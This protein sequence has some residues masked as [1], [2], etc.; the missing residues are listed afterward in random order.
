[1]KCVPTAVIPSAGIVPG[2]VCAP[3]MTYTAMAEEPITVNV[4][5]RFGSFRNSA[6]KTPLQGRIRA[7]RDQ[8]QGK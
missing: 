6:D 5:Q 2:A 4:D 7:V 3:S 1:V 8:N